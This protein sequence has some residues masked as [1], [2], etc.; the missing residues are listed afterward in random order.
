[1]SWI[2]PNLAELCAPH[3]TITS[4]QPSTYLFLAFIA[5]LFG[6]STDHNYPV[7][8][9]FSHYYYPPSSDWSVTPS[10]ALA[11]APTVRYSNYTADFEQRSPDE[12]P[13][14]FLPLQ[15]SF[16]VVYNPRIYVPPLWRWQ[17]E[18][19]LQKR[20]FS[21]KVRE[22]RQRL[23]ARSDLRS[24]ARNRDAGLSNEI[25]YKLRMDYPDIRTMRISAAATE[26]DGS[27]GRVNFPEPVGFWPDQ[28]DFIIVGAGSAG[29]V[30]A[31]RLS[32]I[33]EWRVCR[34]ILRL[35]RHSFYRIKKYR[36]QEILQRKVKARARLRFAS[37]NDTPS[38]FAGRFSRWN[39]FL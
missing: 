17:T 29:C 13:L 25:L 14:I 5:R 9:G 31:N 7:L 35:A 10:N 26:I 36:R 18:Q 28:Y 39:A 19:Q 4:C 33:K 11:F 6:Y 1:M 32:E 3:S 12:Q 8:E 23:I 16:K 27:Y 24:D 22:P 37:A 15:S 2:P 34:T 30:L 38:R 20:S 21:V